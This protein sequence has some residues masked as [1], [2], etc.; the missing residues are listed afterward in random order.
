MSDTSVLFPLPDA[1]VTHVNRPS[2]N[3]TL[4]SLRLFSP[5]AHDGQPSYGIFACRLVVGV[6]LRIGGIVGA[7]RLHDRRHR[8]NRSSV[9][10]YR[11]RFFE[12]Q[13]A[14]GQRLAFL[15]QVGGRGGRGDLATGMTGAGPE[16]EYVVGGINHF[17]VM[18]DHH[19]R[20]AQVTQAHER[21]DQSII[22]ARVQTY[23]RLI[24]HVEYT[25]KPGTNL[26]GQLNSLRFTAGKR[27]C[28]AGAA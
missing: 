11:N 5:R 25:G 23:R 6:D 27:R 16:V 7:T 9:G 2:G 13:I 3:D 4:I 14:P 1:P 18:L 17:P 8:G 21:L 28:G 12:R 24:E 22:V 20:V 10:R 15:A 26:C 19:K